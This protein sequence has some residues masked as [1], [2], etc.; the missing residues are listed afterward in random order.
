MTI[1]ALWRPGLESHTRGAGPEHRQLSWKKRKNVYDT[2]QIRCSY[3]L[4]KVL[5]TL[6]NMPTSFKPNWVDC[7]WKSVKWEREDRCYRLSIQAAV[8]EL[9]LR[10]FTFSCLNAEHLRTSEQN[11]ISCF[12]D[13]ETHTDC[14]GKLTIISSQFLT[15]YIQQATKWCNMWTQH[16]Q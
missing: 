11:T 10:V 15:H 8:W 1:K 2:V 3:F 16:S 4:Q 9:C 14:L 7:K 12:I 13:T 5:W 6:F